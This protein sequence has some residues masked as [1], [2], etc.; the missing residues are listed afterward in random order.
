MNALT[1]APPL[2][3]PRLLQLTTS[4]RGRATGRPEVGRELPDKNPQPPLGAPAGAAARAV[5][6]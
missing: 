6:R 3:Q 2:E 4:T 5:K 1:V